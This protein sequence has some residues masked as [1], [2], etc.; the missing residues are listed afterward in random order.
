MLN[1]VKYEMAS[2]VAKDI[3]GFDDDILRDFGVM[4]DDTP[5]DDKKG[6]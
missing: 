5:S 6:K 3:L 4:P 1:Y 2:D